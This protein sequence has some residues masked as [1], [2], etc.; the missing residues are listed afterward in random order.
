MFF[1]SKPKSEPSRSD[2]V[3]RLDFV[4]ADL[5]AD[6]MHPLAI[7]ELLEG[8]IEGLRMHYATTYPVI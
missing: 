8:R 2:I 5:L 7:A 4:L 1:Q 3:A 6:R